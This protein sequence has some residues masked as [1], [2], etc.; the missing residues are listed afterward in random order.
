MVM[1]IK[2]I[3]FGSIMYNWEWKI[4][5]NPSVS[6]GTN[7]FWWLKDSI[8][9]RPFCQTQTHLQLVDAKNERLSKQCFCSKSFNG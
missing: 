3:D 1:L 6:Y 7:G 8:A 5:T 9:T 4:N 2:I